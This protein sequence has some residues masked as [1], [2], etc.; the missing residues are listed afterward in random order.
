MILSDASLIKAFGKP[1]FSASYR[2]AEV[3]TEERDT[4]REC[5]TQRERHTGGE[6][7]RE[8]ETE[9]FNIH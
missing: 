7:D 3:Y 5:E 6:R 1:I 4:E 8:R 2:M 9:R